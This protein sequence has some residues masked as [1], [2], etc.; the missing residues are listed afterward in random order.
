M[1]EAAQREDTLKR[2]VDDQK[3]YIGS[4]ETS[5]RNKSNVDKELRT[6]K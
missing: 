3:A 1:D 6:M 5:I 4:L 2:E